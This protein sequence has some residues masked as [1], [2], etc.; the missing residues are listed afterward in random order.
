MRGTAWCAETPD[1]STPRFGLVQLQEG[2]WAERVIEIAN[3][4]EHDHVP[5]TAGGIVP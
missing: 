5:Q 3:A 4:V 1:D 2:P